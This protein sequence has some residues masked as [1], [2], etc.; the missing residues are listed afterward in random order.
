MDVGGWGKNEARLSHAFRGDARTSIFTLRGK[1]KHESNPLASIALSQVS[2]RCRSQARET[3]LSRAA[4][5]DVLVNPRA[6][7]TTSRV[8]LDSRSPRNFPKGIV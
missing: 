5:T 6:K 7:T 3:L 1:D 4:N 8:M 2:V